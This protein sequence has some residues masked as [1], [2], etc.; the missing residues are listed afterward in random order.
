M[1]KFYERL[2]HVTIAEAGVEPLK[3]RHLAEQT[4]K[5]GLP[6]GKSVDMA[7]A[8]ILACIASIKDKYRNRNLLRDEDERYLAERM[9]DKFPHWSINDVR[10]FEDMLVEARIPT[11]T[12]GDVSYELATLNIPNLL[13]KAEVYDSMRPSR[14][15]V[16]NEDPKSM[17]ALLEKR[18]TGWRKSPFNI[19]SDYHKTHDCHGNL[20]VDPAKF[21]GTPPDDPGWD[22]EE[23]WDKWYRTHKLGGEPAPDD[24]DPIAYWLTRP[25]PEYNLDEEAF[26]NR[27]VEKDKQFTNKLTIN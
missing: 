6:N 22:Y 25:D 8:L 16:D 4:R 19:Y 21:G 11:N 13:G 10:C 5:I 17:Q 3:L 7:Q 2:P 9:K 20:V 26:M 15:T 14:L 27:V 24:F 18:S 23:H 1:R 12:Y